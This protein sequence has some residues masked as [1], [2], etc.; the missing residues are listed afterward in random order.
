MRGIPMSHRT[1]FAAFV[2]ACAVLLATAPLL[3]QRPTGSGAFVVR[4]GTD[5]TAVERY[6]RTPER[7][8]AVAVSRVP[9][10]LVRELTVTFGPEGRVQR[11][12]TTVRRPGGEEPLAGRRVIVGEDSATIRTTEDGETQVRRVA[13]PGPVVPLASSHFSL[14]QIII[15]RALETGR[16]TIWVLREEPA[17]IVVRRTAPDSVALVTPG[18][19]T[20]R[21]RIDAEGRILGMDTG[22]LG[23][24]V[25]R[26]PW[27][28]TEALARA[29]G[30]GMGVLSP[31]DT[32]RAVIDGAE[33]WVDYGRPQKRGR[34]VFGGLVPWNTVWRTGAN[35]ATHFHTSEPLTIAG[36]PVPAGTYTI[37]TI[38]APTG[39]TLI[40]NE[41]TGQW[42]TVYEPDRDL[43]RIPMEATELDET[44]EQFTIR[45]E[46]TADGGRLA[47]V[48][49]RTK[50]WVPFD[51]RGDAR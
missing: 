45:I 39:W 35:K 41:Q 20:W 26:V 22:A 49:E 17:P 29:W 32:T 36:I 48:W 11:F 34:V 38:P 27:L 43:A 24:S 1:R 2:A 37:Y 10:T 51:V 12:E 28:D 50:A 13:I 7:L 16:D 8:H 31:R 30:E 21:V 14:Y 5:T 47:L 44:V 6:S 42:G 9:E 23:R 4:L 15:Q 25:E 18:L 46:E 40:L 19:G 33:L 3:A